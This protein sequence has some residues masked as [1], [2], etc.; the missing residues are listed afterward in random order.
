MRK[1]TLSPFQVEKL[2]YYFHFFEPNSDGSLDITSVDRLMKRVLT[3][4]N[5][6]P[7][8]TKAKECEEIHHAFFEV[9]FEKARVKPG[10]AKTIS[11]EVWL[12][13]WASVLQGCMGVH[14]FPIWLRILPKTLFNMIDRNNDSVVGPTELVAFYRDMVNIPEQEAEARALYAYD[15]MTDSGRWPLNIESY[16]M[17]FSNFLIGKT[18]FGPGRHIFGCFEHN[19]QKF[20][21]IQ[22]AT[23]NEKEDVTPLVKP[24]IPWEKPKPKRQNSRGNF[25]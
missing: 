18:P 22:P 2:K 23:D 8:G 14:H 11:L 10:G 7:K 13:M 1:A 4:T 17:I 19:A 5:W 21:L 24:A 15:Q 20:E 25:F 12:N 9:L 3:F 6:D 16:E